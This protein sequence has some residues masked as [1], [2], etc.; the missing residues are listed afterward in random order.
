MSREVET[1]AINTFAA[2]SAI[3]AM[4]GH[5]SAGMPA[6]FPYHYRETDERIPYPHITVARFGQVTEHRNFGE[7]EFAGG[8]DDPRLSFCTWSTNSIEECWQLYRLMDKYLQPSFANP[9]PQICNQYFSSYG[10]IKRTLLRDDLFDEVAKAY[11]I[12]SEY[13]IRIQLT[14]LAQP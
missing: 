7:T 9:N 5:N 13:H 11:H 1:W 14:S 2:D 10:T 12:H 4:V 3:A 8:M 6:I